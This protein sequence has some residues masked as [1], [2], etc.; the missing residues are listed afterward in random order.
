VVTDEPAVADGCAP[1]FRHREEL[2]STSTPTYLLVHGAWHSGEA[3]QR[4]VPLLAAAGHRALAPSL[5]GHGDKAELL[6]PEVGLDTYVEDI[7]Q[8]ITEE[9]L[10]DVVLVGHSYAGLVISS[11][12][13]EVPDRIAHLVYLDAMV[14]VHGETAVDVMPFTQALIDRAAQSGAEAWRI[15]P[16]PE[17]SAP[18]G[19]FGVTD[20]ADAAWVRGLLSD[21]S[22]RCYQQPVRLDNPAAARIPRTHIHCVGN[23]PEGIERRPVPPI[24]PNGTPAQVWELPTGH[25]CMVTM[26]RELTDLLLKLG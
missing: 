26:P 8:V 3:W 24:Q 5:T 15:P 13:N 12:A 25:D 14:P 21:E 10:S 1:L 9:D 19:L 6:G 16:L 18:F 23:E 7:V 2:M 17:R 20:P 4:V 11:V 22:V